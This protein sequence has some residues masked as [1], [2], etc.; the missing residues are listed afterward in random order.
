MV[1]FEIKWSNPYKMVDD[2]DGIEK[3]RRHWII[4]PEHRSSF[5]NFWNRSKFKLW[6]EGFSIT[7]QDTD[8]VLLET[9][10]CIENF[11]AFKGTPTPKPPEEQTFWL[12]PYEVKDKSGL[13]PWQIESVSK[14]VSSINKYRCGIDGSDLGVG[15]TYVACA[16][17]S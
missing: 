5:F 9:E 2:K 1:N 15:K 12:P 4:P 13:R 17:L 6:T 10:L 14:L 11:K 7:K 3:W 8:W 16:Y